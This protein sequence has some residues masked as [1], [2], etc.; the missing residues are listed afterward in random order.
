MLGRASALPLAAF[1]PWLGAALACLELVERGAAVAALIA[2]L[3]VSTFMRS[4]LV[5][6]LM[7]DEGLHVPNS[8]G[9]DGALTSGAG[10]PGAKILRQIRS[11]ACDFLRVERQIAV[12]IV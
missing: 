7:G 2:D 9:R 10:Q 5:R 11:N 6:F 12:G 4:A 1:R 3:N 8:I